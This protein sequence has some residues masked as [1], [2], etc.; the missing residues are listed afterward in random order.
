MEIFPVPSARLVLRRFQ[1]KDLLAFVAYRSDP[2]IARFQ[3]WYSINEDE[4]LRFIRGQQRTQFGVPGKWVQAAIAEKETDALI[5]DVGVC[6]KADDP[7]TAEIGFTLSREHQGRGYASEA[8]M[9]VL[10]IIFEETDVERVEGV[11]DS[12]NVA[13]KGLLSR[14]GMTKS[15]A[16][17]A[18]FKGSTCIEYTY[19]IRKKDWKSRAV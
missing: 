18:Q 9:L 4:A 3:S 11:T 17:K 15:K 2:E 5:G 12:R 16:E 13:S 1:D 10:R 14:V 19:E 8:V 6:I 7:T